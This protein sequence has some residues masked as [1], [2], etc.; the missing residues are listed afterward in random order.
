LPITSLPPM[1][2][3]SGF[4]VVLNLLKSLAINVALAITSFGLGLLL[5][6]VGLRVAGKQLA[7][8]LQQA[9]FE[10]ATDEDL[11]T[12]EPGIGTMTRPNLNRP[13]IRINDTE[14]ITVQ[15][16]RWGFRNPPTPATAPV[17]FLGDSFVWGF[18]VEESATWVQ[19]VATARGVVARGYGQSGF[20]SW[21]YAQVFDRYVA[22]QKP[23]LVI[24][25]FF[26]ND[27]LPVQAGILGQNRASTEAGMEV[28]IWLDNNTLVYR[29]IKYIIQ[30]A[31]FSD[32]QPIRYRDQDLDLVLFPST[33]TILDPKSANFAQGLKE[34]TAGLQDVQRQCQQTCDF[35]MVII[36][37]KEM[38][39][40]PKVQSAFT[41]E[42]RQLVQLAFRTYG[43]LKQTFTKMGIRYLD[44][45]P[46]FQKAALP[47]GAP[48]R[49]L[50]FRTDGHWN[51]AGHRVAAEAL[52]EWLP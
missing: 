2:N 52:T 19:Q 32:Q 12:F 31:F 16:D 5:L 37:T 23:K 7:A 20:S 41:P 49:Q 35:V 47:V 30:G 46:A 44:L 9:L 21:Q 43:E 14:T 33:H 4:G 51:R 27:L 48:A 39:Y 6:E 40:Y 1:G 17:A 24:W 45:T 34:L 25:S 22:P 36:P 10:R 29:F 26:A 11:F 15:T 8:P 3:K 38:V 28:R 13:N 42:Q 18:G 50:Y